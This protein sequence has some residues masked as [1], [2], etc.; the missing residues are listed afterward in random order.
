MT[1]NP[2]CL[3]KKTHKKDPRHSKRPKTFKKPVIFK[4]PGFS[5]RP[6][7]FK[8]TQDI[9]KDLRTYIFT[10]KL[11]GKPVKIHVLYIYKLLTY[12]LLTYIFYKK[13]D[14]MFSTFEST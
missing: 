1:K 5:K 12:K 13:H 8:K 11:T 9:Q 10:K 4:K 2:V 3:R 14:L 6:K 7:T